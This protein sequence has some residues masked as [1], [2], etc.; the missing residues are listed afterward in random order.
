MRR[1]RTILMTLAALALAAFTAAAAAQGSKTTVTFWDAYSSDGPEVKQLE[2]VIIPAFEKAHPDITVK[3]VTIPYDNL[4]QKLITAV[5][6]AQLPDLVRSDIIW[7]P[8]LA[9]LG[10]LAPLDQAMPDFK[11]FSSDVFSGPLA[12]NFWK[13]HYYGLPLDTNTRI[14]VYDPATLKALGLSGPPQTFAQLRSMSAT[15]KE[16]GVDL[17]AESGTGGWNILPWIWSN[18]GRLTNDSYTKATGYLNGPKSVAAVQMLVDLYK[19]GEM[20]NIIVNANGGLGTYDGI[21]QHKYASM[22]DGPWAFAIFSS[23][24]PSATLAGSPVP[25][26]PGG[27][28]S[29]VG[30]EDIV[31]TQQSRHKEAALTF[32]RY[33]LGTFAQRQMAEAGQMPVL[34]SSEGWLPTIHPYYATYLEQ[35]ATAR[36]RTPTPKW[37]QIDQVLTNDI[38]KAFQGSETVQ[39]ALDDAA[40]QIDGLLQ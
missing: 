13:G 2:T 34:K 18:G 6:G 23:S 29:V 21:N 14:W 38:A 12:T 33:M 30:G 3:D 15:A 26:G 40:H 39:Q 4:H 36:P 5:A 9:N 11:T 27:S 31:L 19:A 24:Y 16:Q 25:A 7:V 8:E 10:V 35:I 17:Y 28:V 1:N 22:L 20:P 37:P 32:L